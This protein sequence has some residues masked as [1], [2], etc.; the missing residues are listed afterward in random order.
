M[1]KGP[2]GLLS[3]K[4]GAR[5]AERVPQCACRKARVG[6]RVS[7]SVC[8][9]KRAAE[10]ELQGAERVLQSACRSQSARVPQS[11]CQVPRMLNAYQRKVRRQLKPEERAEGAR[12]EAVRVY[13]N[14]NP[15]KLEMLR[16]LFVMSNGDYEGLLKQVCAKYAH[17]LEEVN[18]QFGLAQNRYWLNGHW[19]ALPE[20]KMDV[21]EAETDKED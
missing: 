8:R 21:E 11:A 14:V 4:A 13:E 18:Y 1:P 15:A 5:A 7:E 3:A 19:R 10:R 16:T 12:A 2:T 6:E 9:R 17:Q 20:H